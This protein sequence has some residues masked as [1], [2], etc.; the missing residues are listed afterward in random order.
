[1]D[2]KQEL[3][4]D[5]QKAQLSAEEILRK[6]D[7]ESD[8]REL[9][10]TWNTIIDVICIAFA[11]FQLYTAAFGVLD[12][13]LQRAVHLAFG[14]ALIFLLYPAR[15]SWSRKEMHWADVGFSILGVC[16][17]LYIVVFYHDLVLRAGM[18]NETDFMVGLLGV[19]LVVEGA[20]R[21]VGWPIITIAMLFMVYALFGNYVPGILAHRGLGFHEI[22]NYLFYTTEG[23]FGTPMG[24]SSTFIYL[25]ILFGAYL[26]VTGLGKFFI[27][28]SNAI[29]GWASGGPAKVAVISSALEGT[30]SGSSVANTVGSG[31]FTIPMMKKLGYHPNFAGAVEAAASTGG[32]LMPPVMGA[33]AFLMA[34][35]V[36]VPYMDV[37]KAGI[38]PALLYFTGIWLGVHFEAK[39]LGLKGMSR[40]EMP[41]YKSIFIERGHLVIPL[42]AIIYFLTS[43]YTPM[44]AALVGIGLALVSAC[45]RK[46]TRIGIKDVVH[47]LI[48]GSKGILGVL[49]ACATAGII[50]GV[51]TKTGVG[52]KMATALLDIAGGHLLPAMVFTMLTSLILGM[53]VPTTANYV[54]TST[55][56]APA[57][58]QMG[59]PVLAAHMF[60]FYFGIVA[61]ITPPVALAAY[62]ASGISGGDPLGTGINASKL[63]IAA[64]II[65]YIFV[66]SP[67]ILMID[68]TP[69]GVVF[70]C[71]T[72]IVGMVGVA[73][74]MGAFF[75]RR[76]NFA[77]RALFFFGG[78]GLIDPGLYTD[79][80]GVAVM[81]VGYLW[82]RRNP[83]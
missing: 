74:A 43:G 34:E 50:I 61:D 53:G 49:V 63:A 68:A 16:A 41:S 30:V 27:D 21:V 64:F 1:M 10:G 60:V 46:T 67:E 19:A 18:N 3:M 65:P 6:Y 22:I 80:I 36:G 44:R 31:S 38:I 47:G 20:R 25:F 55:I 32:Q 7:K 56:A 57:L 45:L 14:F 35:F 59:V 70:S 48:N 83:K 28:I 77:Q 29:A 82:S 72:A 66:L 5:I 2:L 79:I 13:M 78:L 26:E 11:V 17:T 71:C 12:A 76:L 9:T 62:A 54:I 4:D 81:A 24:V 37:V 73:A 58:V 8:K 69:F 75:T 23:V 40:D 15:K 39:K 33:A 52:L 42:V 51:V